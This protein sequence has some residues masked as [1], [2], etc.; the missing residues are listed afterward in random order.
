M[1]AGVRIVEVERIVVDVPFTPRCQ[2]WN[3][4]EVWQWRI[5]EVIRVTTDAPDVV[6]YGETILHYTW[7]RVSDE[8]I[9]KVKGRNPA[10][11]LGDDS[12]GAGLQ[13][14][15]YD[16]VGKAMGV[17]AYR[18][19]GLPRVREWCPIS[20]WNIDMPPEAFAAEAQ[21]ALAAGYTSYKIKARPWWDVYEQVDTISRVT[22]PHFRLDLD[23]NNMLLNAGNA[24]PVLTELDK[25]ERVAIYES[26]IMQR[27]VEGHRQLRQKTTRPIALHFGRTTV[28]CCGSG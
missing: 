20:W 8:A 15:L 27:D 11:F 28:P 13:M 14:A 23:W 6:G 26:P 18:L 16:V 22:P 7:G 25:Q 4:R 5:S 17:P 1:A 3:A 2:E 19:L 21:D 9:A 12:L 10:E 24:A